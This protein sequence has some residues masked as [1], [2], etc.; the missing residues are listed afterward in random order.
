MGVAETPIANND[1]RAVPWID[2][3]ICKDLFDSA[4]LLLEIHL[5]G[6]RLQP[7]ARRIAHHRGRFRPR[8][9][10]PPAR[11][12][13]WTSSAE[14]QRQK[15]FKLFS[16]MAVEVLTTRI[17]RPRRWPCDATKWRAVEA[18]RSLGSVGEDD[19]DVDPMVDEQGRHQD[20]MVGLCR[21]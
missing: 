10:L 3:Q 21:V 19:V 14:A 13:R 1:R 16:D 9:F 18:A 8:V 5:R 7:E 4:R 17:W 12:P 2:D 6:C 20:M 11:A 15:E